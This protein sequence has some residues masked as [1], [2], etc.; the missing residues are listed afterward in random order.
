M[1]QDPV[2]ANH[3]WRTPDLDDPDWEG[4]Q[5]DLRAAKRPRKSLSRDDHELEG[6]V[7]DIHPDDLYYFGMVAH[8]GILHPDEFVDLAA[9]QSGMEQILGKSLSEIEA[10]YAPGRPDPGRSASMHFWDEEF[11]RIQDAGGNM[12]LLAKV[13][14]WKVQPHGECRKM[15]KALRRARQRR[16]QSEQS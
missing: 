11:L 1:R 4:A 16:E 8:R 2:G 9:L 5:V 6:E 10:A 14:G 12:L 15:S 3:G 13:L 7:H